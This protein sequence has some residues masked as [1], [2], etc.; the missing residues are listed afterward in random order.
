MRTLPVAGAAALVL[1]GVAAGAVALWPGSATRATVTP[2]SAPSSPESS[3]TSPGALDFTA[4]VLPPGLRYLSTEHGPPNQFE[5]LIKRYTDSAHMHVLIVDVNRG[6]VM[7]PKS[8]AEGT[9][10]F[11]LTTIDGHPAAVGADHGRN[12][13]GYVEVFVRIATDLTVDVEDRTGLSLAQVVDVVRG[14]RVS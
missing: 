10:G 13:A 1:A 3:S 2:A 5:E 7:T 9:G 4:T 12:A 11:T 8:Y 14:I 6:D